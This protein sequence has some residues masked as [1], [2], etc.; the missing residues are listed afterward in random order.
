MMSKWEIPI[1]KNSNNNSSSRNNDDNR[2]DSTSVVIQK[3]RGQPALGVQVAF[4]PPFGLGGYGLAGKMQVSPA[5]ALCTSSRCHLLGRSATSEA[6]HV[7]ASCKSSWFSHV[8]VP[9][10]SPMFHLF[11]HFARIPGS[12]LLWHRLVYFLL[13][14]GKWGSGSAYTIP[15]YT[16][17]MVPTFTPPLPFKHQHFFQGSGLGMRV[18]GSGFR[19]WGLGIMLLKI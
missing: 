17:V 10:A 9:C 16:P 12:P 5:L 6:S 4:R 11:R 1:C 3:A 2:T 18:Q 13:L 7:S 8:F 14:K 15:I 19:V